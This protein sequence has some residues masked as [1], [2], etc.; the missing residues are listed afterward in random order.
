MGTIPKG[1]T[2]ISNGGGCCFLLLKIEIQKAFEGFQLWLIKRIK[3]S[4]FRGGRLQTCENWANLSE[5]DIKGVDGTLLRVNCSAF[6][7]NGCTV[8]LVENSS[9]KQVQ[10][11]RSTKAEKHEATSN[12]FLL[13]V[14]FGLTVYTCSSISVVILY[15]KYGSLYCE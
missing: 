8:S 15:K 6:L 14:D 3:T 7:P 5:R 11:G 12:L 4:D 13:L 9:G 10:N 2:K 1:E